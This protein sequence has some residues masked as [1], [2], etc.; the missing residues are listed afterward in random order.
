MAMEFRV[1]T[2]ARTRPA[3][4][5]SIRAGTPDLDEFRDLISAQI[6][7]RLQG[8]PLIP[9]RLLNA[10]R[11]GTLMGKRIRP[12]LLYLI[13]GKSAPQAALDAGV[14]LEM[15]HS[16]SLILDDLPAMDNA[17]LRRGKPTLH[18]TYGEATAILTAIGLI[19]EAT[20]I[21]AEL[22][23]VTDDRRLQLVA[24]L[25]RAIG[26]EGLSSGQELDLNGFA[27]GDLPGTDRGAA[28]S[29]ARIERVNA[30][31]TCV[32]LQAAVEMGAVLAGHDART[33][34]SLSGFAEH[35]GHAFQIAD[36]LGDAFLTR[37]AAG[38]DT[39]KD[40]AKETYLAAFGTQAALAHCHALLASASAALAQGELDAGRFE[41]LMNR[42]FVPVLD[43]TNAALADQVRA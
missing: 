24:I 37:E 28:T 29:Q 6:R 11:D 20:R 17:E 43:A 10:A 12:Y 5:P 15:M 19:S 14:A 42:V 26:F 32:L 31:K 16:A 36:D 13:A 18:R 30:L 4:S 33:R 23:G 39:G 3:E 21:V 40:G 9:V 8:A 35:L 38:K 2:G 34:S 7:E 27:E 25:N 1:E 22:P 41:P